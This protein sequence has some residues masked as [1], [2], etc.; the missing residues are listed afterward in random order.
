[1]GP[2]TTGDTALLDA[3]PGVTP[4]DVGCLGPAPCVAPGDGNGVIGEGVPV[5]FGWRKPGRL[6]LE[7]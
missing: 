7:P 2:V 5:I 6:G 4:G 1:M 3:A